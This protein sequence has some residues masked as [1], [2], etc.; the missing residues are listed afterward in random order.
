M[1]RTPVPAGKRRRCRSSSTGLQAG[2]TRLS[3]LRPGSVVG[4]AG[5]FQRPAAHGQ[6]RGDDQLRGLGAARPR[7]RSWPRATRR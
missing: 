4:E 2:Q 6:C 1:T 3:L 5:L 7:L